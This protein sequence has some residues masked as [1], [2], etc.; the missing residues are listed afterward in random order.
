[1]IERKLRGRSP[2]KGW[3]VFSQF[4]RREAVRLVQGKAG[5]YFWQARGG[6]TIT[7]VEQFDDRHAKGTATE[8]QERGFLVPLEPTLNWSVPVISASC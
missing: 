6:A 5:R 4:Y 2:G 8:H 7:I 1:M 3:P